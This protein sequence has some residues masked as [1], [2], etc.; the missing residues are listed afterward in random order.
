MIKRKSAITSLFCAIAGISLLSWS[1][2]QAQSLTD[3][4]NGGRGKNFNAAWK[5]NLGDVTGA[6]NAGFNDASW[7][8]LNVPH[9]WSIELPYNQ[10]SPFGDGGGYLDGGTVAVSDSVRTA[11]TPERILLTP[12]RTS[13]TADGEDLVFI[14]ADIL[15][16]SGVIHPKAQN[17]VQF[18]ITGPGAIV[19]VDNGNSLDHSAYKATS[20]NAFGGK[21]LAVIRSSGTSIDPIVVTATSSGLAPGS[22]TITSGTTSVISTHYPPKSD[23]KSSTVIVTVNTMSIPLHMNGKPGIIHLYDL[24]G[25]LMRT[26]CIKSNRINMQKDFGVSNGC[27]IFLMKN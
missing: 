8:S 15:D 3:T 20:R 13:I 24:T 9:D 6:Q 12:D 1:I 18:S 2:G 16:A 26:A 21:C 7:R 17:T 10:N 14:T 11:G 4:Y 25:R 19:G 23:M 22:V 27:Y 5:F